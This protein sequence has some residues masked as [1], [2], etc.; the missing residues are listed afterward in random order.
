MKQE[1]STTIAEVK[2]PGDALEQFLLLCADASCSDP[3]NNWHK[4]FDEVVVAA[5][6]VPLDNLDPDVATRFAVAVWYFSDAMTESLEQ[7]LLQ[8]GLAPVRKRRL[9]YLVDRLRRFPVMAPEQ[10]SRMKSFVN[11]WRYLT[12]TAGEHVVRKAEKVNRYDKVAVTWGLAENVSG[13]MSKVLEFQT[14]HFVDEHAL[15]SGYSEL[16]LRKA[17]AAQ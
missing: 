1:K 3:A 8:P 16:S 11:H 14:R 7:R 12:S 10:A 2:H 4:V 6:K 5:S 15:P 13:L 17:A 9:M